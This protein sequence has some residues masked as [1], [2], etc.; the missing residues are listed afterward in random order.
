MP[1][2]ASTSGDDRPTALIIEDDPTLGAVLAY[3]LGHAGYRVVQAGDGQAGLVAARQA[4]DQLAV[5]LLDR[6][7]PELDGLA[8]PAPPAR[9]PSD[10]RR[11]RGGALGR[12]R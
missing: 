12:P 7:L 10:H 11:G 1:P 4:G 6:L 5:V 9:R 2:R 8:G 3:N